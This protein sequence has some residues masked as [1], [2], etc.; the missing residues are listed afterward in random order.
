MTQK[1]M[2]TRSGA[3]FSPY[4]RNIGVPLHVAQDFNLDASVRD[5]L[6]EG[7]SAFFTSTPSLEE[8]YEDDTPVVS[9][10]LYPEDIS[11]ESLALPVILPPILDAD[12]RAHV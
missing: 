11:A 3:A 6:C 10:G 7:D 12:R 1:L 2:Q 8:E 4:Y 5:A 9:G